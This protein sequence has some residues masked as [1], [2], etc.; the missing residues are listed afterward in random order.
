MS[1]VINSAHVYHS[2]CAFES[3]RT[4]KVDGEDYWI[5]AISSEV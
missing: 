4:S 2:Q 5:I 3:F 1:R